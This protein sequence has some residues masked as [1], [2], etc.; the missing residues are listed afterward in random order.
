MLRGSTPKLDGRMD[1]TDTQT[2]VLLYARKQKRNAAICRVFEIWNNIQPD[3]TYR[4]HVI[5]IIPND[6]LL[7]EETI[8]IM[9]YENHHTQYAD[10]D[11]R[12]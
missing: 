10:V 2:F 1:L 6:A 4:H 12:L 7:T 5:Y 11:E 3:S 9:K 8:I